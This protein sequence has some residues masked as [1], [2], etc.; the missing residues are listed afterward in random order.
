MST[1]VV[2]AHLATR[3]AAL[4]V[5]AAGPGGHSAA[6]VFALIVA[7]LLVGWSLTVLKKTLAPFFE[8]VQMLARAA[9]VALLTTG[10]FVA[11]VVA[12]ALR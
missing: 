9:F 1:L 8:M 12:L 4:P 7:I 2:P 11:L 5:L 10:A 3:Q 6:A